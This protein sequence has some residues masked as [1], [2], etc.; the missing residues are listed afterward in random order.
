MPSGINHWIYINEPCTCIACTQSTICTRCM[1]L[2]TLL[3]IGYH[4][5]TDHIQFDMSECVI[6]QSWI[7]FECVSAQSHIVFECLTM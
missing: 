2:P 6:M 4:T 1:M 7:V 3:H 5:I